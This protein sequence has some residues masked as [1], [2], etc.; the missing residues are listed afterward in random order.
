MGAVGI[1]DV[2]EMAKICLSDSATDQER[3]MAA[4]TILEIVRPSMLADMIGS[5][6]RVD[7]YCL[8]DVAGDLQRR[9]NA[10]RELGASVQD[11]ERSAAFKAKQAAYAR[12]AELVLQ[13]I[14][15]FGRKAVR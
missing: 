9:A 4:T 1:G 3:D 13:S 10:C 15:E 7:K 14:G 2:V 12:S 6:N 8:L 11:A 5:A